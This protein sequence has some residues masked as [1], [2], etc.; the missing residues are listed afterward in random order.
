[1]GY[2]Q[3]DIGLRVLREITLFPLRSL[4][5]SFI[6]QLT[7]PAPTLLGA[8][9]SVCC[10]GFSRRGLLGSS[11]RDCRLELEDRLLS[12]HNPDELRFLQTAY[13]R[14][15]FVDVF[16]NPTKTRRQFYMP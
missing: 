15:H 9:C 2:S 10:S 6:P 8:A 14:A 16:R 7:E 12:L 1:M 13:A 3:T 5:P 11:G 4:K